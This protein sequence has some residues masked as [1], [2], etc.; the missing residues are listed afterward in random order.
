MMR[1]RLGGWLY[2]GELFT[3]PLPWALAAA[4][5]SP[6]GAAGAAAALLAV[7]YAAE[8]GLAAAVGRRLCDRDVAL[9]PVRDCA[10][11]GVFWAGLTGR[12]VAWRGPRHADRTGDA[13]RRA[14][15]GR[16]RGSRATA[17]ERP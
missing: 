5:A 6:G 9:L 17:P 7:R 14:A 16:R 4:V 8:I 11:F 3:S 10:V 13:N 12:R 1:R 2:A 15:P